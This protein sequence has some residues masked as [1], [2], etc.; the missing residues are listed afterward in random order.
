MAIQNVSAYQPIQE[1]N[2]HKTAIKSDNKPAYRWAYVPTEI[3]DAFCSNGYCT[4]KFL[5]YF[6]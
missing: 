6:A 3:Y 5:D 1:P 2:N 4:G